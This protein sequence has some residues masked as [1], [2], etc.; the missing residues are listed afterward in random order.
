M[1]RWPTT[2]KTTLSSAL[3]NY[4]A[5][6]SPLE[7]DPV[8]GLRWLCRAT[9]ALTRDNYERRQSHE[10]LRFKVLNPV[11]EQRL[12]IEIDKAGARIEYINAHASADISEKLIRI[13]GMFASD[14]ATERAKAASSGRQVDTRSRGLPLGR[15][16]LAGGL[17]CLK[18]VG[19]LEL[20]T[21][22]SRRRTILR[23]CI[24]GKRTLA[25][26]GRQAWRWSAEGLKEP[27]K[28]LP[29]PEELYGSGEIMPLDFMISEMRRLAAEA[30]DDL[31]REARM[32]AQA[33][34]PYCHPRLQAIVAKTVEGGDTLTALLKA[35]DGT[36][37]GIDGGDEFEELALEAKQL[38]HV[39]H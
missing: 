7:R 27:E 13:C 10:A 3:E 12:K 29:H 1:R 20:E 26:V 8:A 18:A 38:I 25:V 36:T 22:P 34:A 32:L 16:Y 21:L 37:L 4:V 39:R 11:E 2:A 5:A 23:S 28:Q 14:S 6:E 24:R 30:T 33:A 31:L 35:I 15:R 19:V 9:T 17:Q